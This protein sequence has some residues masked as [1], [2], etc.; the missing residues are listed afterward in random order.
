MR[1]MVLSL[2]RS[3]LLVIFT[4][5]LPPVSFAQVICDP[6]IYVRQITVNDSVAEISVTTTLANPGSVKRSFVIRCG[7]WDK[8]EFLTRDIRTVTLQSRDTM[9]VIQDLDFGMPELWD[10]TR[11]PFLYRIIIEIIENGK[12]IETKNLPLGLRKFG[13]DFENRFFLN[14]SLRPLN[15]VVV[16]DTAEYP[17]NTGQL[18][19]LKKQLKQV[20][21][22][23]ANAVFLPVRL[24]SSSV[25]SLCDSLGL[26]VWGIAG[27][28]DPG[29]IKTKMITDYIRQNCNHPSILF[30]SYGK[31]KYMGRGRLVHT[32]T[33]NTEGP[34][35][36]TELAKMEDPDRLTFHENDAWWI[37]YDSIDE[38][39]D[40]DRVFRYKAR[41][42]E[43]PV[44]HIEGK[45]DT[46]DQ[47]VVR[48]I[49]VCSNIY[50][51]QLELNGNIVDERNEGSVPT[52]FHWDNVVLNKGMNR[53][54]VYVRKKG[55]M[56]E[57]HWNVI[58][59]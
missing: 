59:K 18:F 21:L 27:E 3:C 40:P 49:V 44:I 46:V 34:G 51:P 14:N 10:G 12:I 24:R 32:D 25:F 30:W 41:W 19:L 6:G 1:K 54:R 58:V 57:D 28:N 50:D 11:H 37:P 2:S 53:I 47:D 42:S 17:E 29:E 36:F 5:L 35:K 45:K 13:F 43:E 4:A 22:S 7:I 23:G 48:K 33:I 31:W 20:C 16:N 26:I 39:P 55:V 15:G 52:E 8:R 56:A 9:G 38:R